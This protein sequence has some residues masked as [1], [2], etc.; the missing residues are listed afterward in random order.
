MVSPQAN[1]WDSPDFVPLKNPYGGKGPLMMGVVWTEAGIAI[2][3]LALRA[4]TNVYITKHF[5]WD[6]HFALLTLVRFFFWWPS[7]SKS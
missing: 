1:A 4:Y 2:L 5:A 6:F 7:E 3:M